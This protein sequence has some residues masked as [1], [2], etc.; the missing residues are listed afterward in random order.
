MLLIL[1][2]SFGAGFLLNEEQALRRICKN[3]SYPHEGWLVMQTNQALGGFVGSFILS[4]S[5]AFLWA[6]FVS[7]TTPNF[8]HLAIALYICGNMI[9][10]K[11]INGL[12][13]TPWLTLLGIG[14]VLNTLFFQLPCTAFCVVWLLSRNFTASV[15]AAILS[16]ALATYWT[17][18]G[19][20]EVLALGGL[21]I[22]W[23]FSGRQSQIIGRLIRYR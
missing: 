10:V 4:F 11:Q 19:R 2:L 17:G 16:G 18:L 6:K 15:E 23:Y 3:M 20:D 1:L 5:K 12:Y 21:F 22:T 13:Y 9:A 8:A 7:A 14:V